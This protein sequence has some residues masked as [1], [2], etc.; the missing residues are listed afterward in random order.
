VKVAKARWDLV[1][2][3]ERLAK[4]LEDSSCAASRVGPKMRQVL[5]AEGVD[6]AGGERRLGAD[7]GEVDLFAL[8]E[9]DQFVDRSP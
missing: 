8:G 4:S 3:H 9:G 1:A 2:L 6:H 7:H 5:R